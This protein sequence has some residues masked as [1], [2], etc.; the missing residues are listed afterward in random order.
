MT[1]IKTIGKQSKLRMM[2]LTEMQAG[3]FVA[4]LCVIGMIGIVLI[5]AT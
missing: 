5:L 1:L 4:A 2:D 3:L